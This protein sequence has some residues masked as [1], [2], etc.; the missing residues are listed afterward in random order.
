MARDLAPQSDDA[1]QIAGNE[2][3]GLDAYRGY[4]NAFAR[5]LKSDPLGR[6]S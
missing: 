4:H 1:L 3:E 2:F 5:V 6:A